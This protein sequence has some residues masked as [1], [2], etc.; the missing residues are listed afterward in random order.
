[1]RLATAIYGSMFLCVV[2][3]TAS[4]VLG[5]LGFTGPAP[6]VFAVGIGFLVLELLLIAIDL[7]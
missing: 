4:L 1:M 6:S 2:C 7:W 5:G 3:V